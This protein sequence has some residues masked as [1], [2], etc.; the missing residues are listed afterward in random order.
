MGLELLKG[1]SRV[2]LE[3]NL[4][5]MELLNHER[6]LKPLKKNRISSLKSAHKTTVVINQIQKV[7]EVSSANLSR[8]KHHSKEPKR[9]KSLP[10]VYMNTIPERKMSQISLPKLDE[11]KPIIKSVN[12]VYQLFFKLQASRVYQRNARKVNDVKL[13]HHVNKGE[14]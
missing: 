12:C 7:L 9:R 10:K 5:D 2:R 8:N 1:L 11:K 14:K 4:E 3:L 6:N 13:I